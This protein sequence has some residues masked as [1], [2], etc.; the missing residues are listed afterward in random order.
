[1][2]AE[3]VVYALLSQAS[4]VT[5]LVGAR[6]YPLQ[7]PQD[8]DLP[9]ITYQVIS[10]VE[11]DRLDA[12]SAYTLTQTRISVAWV[13]T[14]YARLKTGLKAV[15]AACWYAR[16]AIAGVQVVSVLPGGTG[17]DLRDT[18]MALFSQSVDFLITH[19][20]P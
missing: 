4:A 12:A 6:I 19:H 5:A 15:R 8:E 9:A 1:M 2:A 20:E 7:V 17:P 3:K 18:D 14:D 10:A 11:L 16:G 13:D